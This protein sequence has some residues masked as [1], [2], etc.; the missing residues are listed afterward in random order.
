MKKLLA[1]CISVIFATACEKHAQDLTSQNMNI[2]VAA[3]GAPTKLRIC[4]YDTRKGTFSSITIN[5]SRWPEHQSHGDIQGDCSSVI[6]TICNQVWMIKNLDVTTYRNGD[7]IPQVT[8]VTAWNNLST[9]AWCYYENNTA[10]GTVYGKLY[11]WY[12]VNDPRGLA[13]PGWHVPNN[14]EWTILTDCLGGEAVAG[15]KMKSI[16]TISGGSGLWVAPNTA[17]TNTS[18]FSGHPGGNVS[19]NSEV[20]FG[21]I[22]ESGL[23]WSATEYDLYSAHRI[24][25][26]FVLG[27]VIPGFNSKKLG[28]SVRCLKDN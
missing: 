17:A 26:L 9:G 13:P 25:L 22:G 14:A 1:F 28:F 15:G 18:G 19:I 20:M 5:A 16:G 23:W 2:E 7:L 12:A 10:N 4:H 21:G 27:N 11:N 8:D 24:N 3:K 6:T